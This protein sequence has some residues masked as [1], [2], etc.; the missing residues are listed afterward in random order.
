MAAHLA[1]YQVLGL[2]APPA[3]RKAV[4]RA[5]SKMLKVTR[6]ED[7]PDGFMRLR[8][9]HDLALDIVAREAQNTAWRAEQALYDAV[10]EQ[11][12]EETSPK[13]SEYEIETSSESNLTYE[14][15]IPEPEIA[16]ETGYS[17]GPTPSLEAPLSLPE[18]NEA[19]P[20]TSYAIG[21]SP[22]LEAPLQ[23][24]EPEAPKPPPLKEMI[25]TLLNNPKAYNDRENWNNLFR[26]ARQLDIDDYVDFEHLLLEQILEFHGYYSN[27]NPLHHTPE[28]MP[29]KLSPSIAASLF[30]TMSWDQVN[31]QGYHIGQQIEW[32]NRRIIFRKQR[33]DSVP[34]PAPEKESGGFGSVWMILLVLFFIAKIVQYL[35][36]A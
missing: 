24:S 8:D 34:V 21:K 13:D 28:K 26:K 14:N 18:D 1:Y 23:F 33:T 7:D 20:D 32:L 12:S 5:Y 22:T 27:N 3:D 4:K 31:K 11:P 15:M 29:Q 6:P 17:I 2:D 36:N 16:S 25:E 35:A 10:P 9:A 19:R 30:K